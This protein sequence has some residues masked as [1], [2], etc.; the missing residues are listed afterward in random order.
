MDGIPIRSGYMGNF[1]GN[2]GLNNST[3]FGSQAGDIN[4]EDVESVTVLKGASA[5]ALYGSQAANGVIIINTKKGV[6]DSKIR[7]AYTGTIQTS[8]ILRTPQLQNMFGEGWPNFDPMENGSWGPRLDGQVRTWGA[9]LDA[10]GVYDDKNGVSRE[11]KFEY[12]K[13]NIRNFYENGM[14][15]VNNTPS[16]NNIKTHN[17]FV[18][19]LK[20]FIPNKEMLSLYNEVL[21]DVSTER[22]GTFIEQ[23]KKIQEEIDTIQSRLNTLEDKWIDGN[24]SDADYYRIKERFDLEKSKLEDKKKEL[25]SMDTNFNDKLNYGMS[26]LNNLPKYFTDA[27]ID[28]KQELIGL[29]FPEKI[30]YDGKKYQTTKINDVF[31]LM[32]QENK[33]LQKR[34]AV[35]NSDMS[36]GVTPTGLKPVTYRTGICRSIR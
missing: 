2:T 9:P 14:E 16:Y 34:H 5:T 36:C 25:L 22:K 32:I 28:T 24:T 33:Q 31:A 11:K 35:Q 1:M 12:V 13:N 19:Y 15:Y 26:L 27:D 18:D 10:T 20:M 3:D 7:V 6:T 4:P 30:Q 17:S 23:S 29:I 8:N 21:K